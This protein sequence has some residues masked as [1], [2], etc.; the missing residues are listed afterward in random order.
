MRGR[1]GWAVGSVEHI[2]T[3]RWG[4][5]ACWRGLECV[6]GK[7]RRAW[8]GSGP[9]MRGWAPGGIAG[10]PCVV[11]TRTDAGNSKADEYRDGALN[12]P[13]MHHAWTMGG[14]KAL[15]LM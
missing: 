13:C 8:S 15:Q 11:V 12:G 6:V 14:I 3:R 4:A 5:V 7:G 10:V 2:G 1:R 9:G